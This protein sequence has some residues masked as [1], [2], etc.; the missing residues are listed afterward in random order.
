MN[1][2]EFSSILNRHI[3]EEEKKELLQK[4]ADNPERFVGLFRPTK[5]GAKVLQHLLQSHEIR[6]GDAME[7]IISF[8]LKELGF[9]ILDKI[10]IPDSANKRK[11]LDIDQYFRDDKIYG[12]IEQKVRDDHDS[13]K[14]KGQI[15]NFEAKLEFLYKKHKNNLTGIMYFIDPDLVKNKN[16]YM[17]EL[18]K[19]K[20]VYGIRLELF[21]GKE[22][23]EYFKRSKLWD[24]IIA[25]LK[26]W[27]DELHEL[28]EI[29]FDSDPEGSFEQI[30]GLEIRYW[31]KILD[32]DKLWEEGIMKV[33]SRDSAI[34]RL[35]LE[36][37]RSNKD[38]PYKKL[39]EQL[40]QKLKRYY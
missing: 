17:E 6:F 5:P 30:K 26:K 35:V 28:P 25:W 13:T 29:N 33:I 8:L 3:F 10:I 38:T 23:F 27:K 40:E 4:L 24:D 11:A 12:F 21:Y 14:K 34:L 19:M 31:R 15:S 22:L 1:Y 7:E 20:G 37:F 36:F 9:E 39:S 16:F 32:N 2:G 18:K